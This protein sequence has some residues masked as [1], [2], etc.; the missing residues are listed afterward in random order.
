MRRRLLEHPRVLKLTRHVDWLQESTGWGRDIPYFDPLDGGV[1]A[2]VLFLFESP[3]EGALASG[4]VSR[5]N[6]DPSAAKFATLNKEADLDRELTASWNT[7]PWALGR[8]P[9]AEDLKDAASLLGPTLECFDR[10]D[11]AVLSGTEARSRREE[12]EGRDIEVWE[13]PHPSPPSL[14]FHPENERKIRQILR[15]CRERCG[16]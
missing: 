11:V 3:G 1:K 8:P 4:F 13:M 14:R 16:A 12:I 2:K 6:R 9:T 10:L 5:D 7:V 15:K